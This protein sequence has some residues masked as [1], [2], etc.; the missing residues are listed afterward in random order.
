ARVTSGGDACMR[1]AALRAARASKFNID[2]SA[3]ARQTGTITY[4]FIPQ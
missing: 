3:P 2:E 1:D 4:V